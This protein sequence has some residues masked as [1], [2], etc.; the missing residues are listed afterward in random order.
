MV[1]RDPR[2]KLTP[3]ATP[4]QIA[5]FAASSAGPGRAGEDRA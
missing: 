5:S 1:S 4:A 2:A 3:W